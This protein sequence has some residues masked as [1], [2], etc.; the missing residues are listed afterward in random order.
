VCPTKKVIGGPSLFKVPSKIDEFLP[1]L[2]VEP[3][4]P[5]PTQFKAQY[6][7]SSPYTS[8]NIAVTAGPTSQTI[9]KHRYKACAI[10]PNNL[11]Y[12]SMAGL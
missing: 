8:P 4:T 6:T 9:T 2:G 5:S 11:Q 7:S 12:I 1:E 10:I 3:G